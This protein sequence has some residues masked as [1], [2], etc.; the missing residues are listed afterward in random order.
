MHGWG[1]YLDEFGR[2]YARLHRNRISQAAS[3]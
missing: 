3:Y 1:R 2:I